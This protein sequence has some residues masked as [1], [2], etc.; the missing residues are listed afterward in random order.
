MWEYK[1]VEFSVLN[2][3]DLIKNLN[4]LGKNGWEA[5]SSISYKSHYNILLKRKLK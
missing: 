4:E 1:R 5:F 3:E 2:D